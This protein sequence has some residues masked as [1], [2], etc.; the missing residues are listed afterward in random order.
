MVHS[1]KK[2]NKRERKMRILKKR[3][4]RLKNI[5]FHH[6]M[7]GENEM[8]LPDIALGDLRKRWRQREIPLHPALLRKASQFKRVKISKDKPLRILGSDNGLL[9]YGVA[10]NDKELVEKLFKSIQEA[11][12]LKHYMFKGKKRS[13]YQ[14]WHWTAWVKY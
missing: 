4:L 9:I 3:V 11:S 2:R 10:L 14:S 6:W 7:K 8:K 12:T 1:V 5:S 13:D